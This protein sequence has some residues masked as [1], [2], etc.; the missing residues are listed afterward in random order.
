MPAY[1]APVLTK[2]GNVVDTTLAKVPPQKER[3]GM[4]QLF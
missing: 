3:N 2:H 1:T 4:P